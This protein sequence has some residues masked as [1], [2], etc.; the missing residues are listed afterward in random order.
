MSALASKSDIAKTMRTRRETVEHPF[1]TEDAHG[2]DAL[3]VQDVAQGR[4]RDGAA[5]DMNRAPIA[6]A[7]SRR[8]KRASSRGGS[9]RAATPAQLPKPPDVERKQNAMQDN[10]GP[11]A[12]TGSVDEE[13]DVAQYCGDAQ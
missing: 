12:K 13:R 9:R 7:A 3:L 2:R 5:T 6:S 11:K 4:D 8:C 10:D 1:G